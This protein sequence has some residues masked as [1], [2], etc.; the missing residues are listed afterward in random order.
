MRSAQSA[1]NY[2][3]PTTII[4]GGWDGVVSCPR[5]G[6]ICDPET[7][8]GDDAFMLTNHLSNPTPGVVLRN[9]E[10]RDF[11]SSQL[12]TVGGY[13]NT[14]WLMENL[15]VHDNI[16]GVRIGE[17][18]RLSWSLISDNY[19]FGVTA[20]STRDGIMEDSELRN[21]HRNEDWGH[22]TWGAS[23]TKF[24]KTTNFII[25]RNYSHHNL[26]PGLWS[27]IDNDGTLFE[28]NLVEDN[29]RSGIQ[30]EVSYSATIRNNTVRRNG[31]AANIYIS[32][33][34]GTSDQ[35]IRVYGNIVEDHP[36]WEIMIYD[37]GTRWDNGSR[38]PRPDH[39]S[40][41]DNTLKHSNTRGRVA[42][43]YGDNGGPDLTKNFKWWG[44]DYTVNGALVDKPFEWG[45]SD[46]DWVG[47]NALADSTSH[48][49]DNTPGA[50]FT[51]TP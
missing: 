37:N 29:L 33:S 40:I 45:D 41:Y 47:W 18:S 21:N 50:S 2:G 39:I 27:D 28:G 38:S 15:Y 10:I 4:D 19:W 42:G 11:E 17:S 30:H 13:A 3:K 9:L 25:R 26:G 6:G 22:T 31:G 12:G 51:S 46:Q 44:N 5:T 20:N 35:P 43:V 8:F 1:T 24:V 49:H 7:G 48:L 14:N 16:H 23:A 34:A 32:N 36:Q